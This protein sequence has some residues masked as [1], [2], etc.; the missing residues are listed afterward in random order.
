MLCSSSRI[1][2]DLVRH[3][4]QLLL[5]A[6]QIPCG[7]TVADSE[8]VQIVSNLILLASAETTR[9]SWYVVWPKRLASQQSD[10]STKARTFRVYHISI[11]EIVPTSPWE[12]HAGVGAFRFSAE[13]VFCNGASLNSR[14]SASASVQASK[15]T[16]CMYRSLVTLVMTA[17]AVDRVV[18]RPAGSQALSCSRSRRRFRVEDTCVTRLRHMVA[19][20]A[21]VLRA[22]CHHKAT[23][24]H[25]HAGM[26]FL[27]LP[28]ICNV[29]TPSLGLCFGALLA[30]GCC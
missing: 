20:T 21:S 19:A 18:R 23:Q 10:T 26:I 27:F 16:S 5:P 9:W 13:G 29:M 22:T 15:T 8:A 30:L 4:K 14:R 17:V 11:A 6:A 25:G 2:Q 7:R 28:S 3:F 1:M 24:A 12:V